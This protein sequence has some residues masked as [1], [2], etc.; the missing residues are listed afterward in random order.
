MSLAAKKHHRSP[1]DL[2][3]DIA[4]IQQDIADYIDRRVAEVK[5]S[6][7]GADLPIETL[8]HLLFQGDCA[9]RAAMRFLNEK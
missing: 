2:A 8:R 3:A 5:A 1:A 9:C 4:R 7:E 6:A